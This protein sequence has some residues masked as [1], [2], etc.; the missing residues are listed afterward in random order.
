MG[1]AG[2]LMEAFRRAPDEREPLLPCS[3]RY[4]LPRQDVQGHSLVA[5]PPPV[6]CL[7]AY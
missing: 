2:P 3:I 7:L 4:L 5:V 1:G 6:T